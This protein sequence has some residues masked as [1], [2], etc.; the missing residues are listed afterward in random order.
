MP[1]L[2]NPARRPAR[3][4]SV[5]ALLVVALAV[6]GALTWQ[7]FDAARSH[8]EAAE[9]AL[10][11]Y[12]AF[13]AWEY[14]RLA[15]FEF[16]WGLW[17]LVRPVF[18]L[19]APV[20]GRLPDRA[21][22]T[23]LYAK[24]PA[25]LPYRPR[26]WF[27]VDL[28]HGELTVSGPD[29]DSALARWVRDTVTTHARTIWGPKWE[30]ATIIDHVAGTRRALTYTIKK[31]AQERPCAAYG[32]E[33]GLGLFQ[34]QLRS[35]FEASTLLPPQ[36]AG[37]ER[38]DSLLSLV[39]TAAEGMELF[40]SQPSFAS[41]FVATDSLD[42][43]IAGL[44]VT[45]G[46]RPEA[47]EALVIG[48]L[49][50]SRMPLLLGLLGL[51]VGLVVIALVQLRREYELARV[52][53]DFVSGVSHELRTPLAQ[54]RMFVET[55]L[56]ERVRSPDEGRKAL[57]IINREAQRLTHLVEN[58]LQFSRAE[59]GTV[60][61][62][63]ESTRLD[64]LIRELLE[65]FVPLASARQATV[66]PELEPGV[67]AMVDP[68]A[69]RQVLLNLLDNAVKY[70][71]TGQTVRVRL[72]LAGGTAR[73]SVEDEGPGI[74][75]EARA[76]VWEPFWRLSRDSQTAVGGSGI[77]LAVV[78]ELVALHNGT[79]SVDDGPT[80]GARFVITIPGARRAATEAREPQPM[81][82]DE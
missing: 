17:T 6:V 60:Q 63:P 22:L 15:N 42:P 73:M 13:A 26:F 39:V 75:A 41:P 36:V 57:D 10:T 46:L 5:V 11:D 1:I 55:L 67:T 31:D 33:I 79:V 69:I 28:E 48:G 24:L 14:S 51:T 38:N 50:R 20:G 74:P 2:R 34:S 65:S 7:A 32:F 68:A 76:Q 70:G 9:A 37:V 59:R 71:P 56:L 49:P 43:A 8:R 64:E 12:A 61:L 21:E 30:H 78:R 47:A 19:P 52:R 40:R 45:V 16:Q 54:I 81:G 66:R 44:N 77:G 35:L 25:T 18:Y 62:S 53:Q 3:A 4:T 82:V 27:A 72:T 80:G 58:V 29:L 23:A